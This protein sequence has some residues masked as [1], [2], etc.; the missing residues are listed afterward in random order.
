MEADGRE[1][2]REA[3]RKMNASLHGLDELRNLGVA[4]V[5]AGICVDDAHYGTRKSVFAVA[6]GFDE[7]FP[8]E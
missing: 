2:Y 5:E 1:F 7:H 3:S 8:Q 4:W 6:G